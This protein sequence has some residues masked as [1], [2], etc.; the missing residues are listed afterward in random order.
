MWIRD[1]KTKQQ[2]E[3]KKKIERK[4]TY[5]RSEIILVSDFSTAN[6]KRKSNGDKLSKI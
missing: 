2:T 3:G 1:T 4:L 5:K 6:V